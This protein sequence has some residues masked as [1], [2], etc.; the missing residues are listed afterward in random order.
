MSVISAVTL[1]DIKAHLRIDG[2]DEDYALLLYADAATAYAEQYLNREI[3]CRTDPE[4]IVK[5]YGTDPTDNVPADIKFFILAL[6]GD[7]Y[8]NREMSGE[9]R[10]TQYHAHVM[11]KWILHNRS[12]DWE[13]DHGE[14]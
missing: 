3:I 4:A 12:T 10:L 2:D 9:A 5:G 1:S 6:V 14:Y 13:P 11:D 8:R 7:Y